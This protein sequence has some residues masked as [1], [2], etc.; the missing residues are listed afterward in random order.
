MTPHWIWRK[1]HTRLTRS[2]RIVPVRASWYLYAPQAKPGSYR[3]RCPVCHTEIISVHFP[4]G[5]W[6][7]FEAKPGLTRVKH[8]CL[9]IG[10]GI[11]RARD[12]CTPDLFD[13]NGDPREAAPIC[14]PSGPLP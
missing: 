3:H 14:A 12:D 13:T 11:G 5:G 6:A 4:R 1:S 9:H 10:E 8:S 2:G 7:H